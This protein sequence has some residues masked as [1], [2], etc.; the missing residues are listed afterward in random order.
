MSLTPRLLRLA[1]WCAKQELEARGNGKTPG[2]QQWN[3][4][5]VRALE[6]ELAVSASG[7]SKG[8]EL[9]GL[10]HDEEWIGTAEAARILRW[11]ERKVRRR[12]PDL[13][14]R[15]VSGQLVFR[16]STVRAYAEAV[17]NGRTVA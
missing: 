16:A 2:V 5:L 7:Q 13:D 11:Y 9:S 12:A 1:L 8:G 3:A 6:L 4:E 14:G 15:K 17:T 10:D